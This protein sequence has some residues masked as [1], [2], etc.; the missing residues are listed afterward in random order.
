MTPER[1][2]AV[3]LLAK[4]RTLIARGVYTLGSRLD[5][6]VKTV[7][8]NVAEASVG[9]ILRA[10]E[11]YLLTND[12]E[13]LMETI[14]TTAQ[15]RHL[16]GYKM[17][18]LMAMSHCYLPVIR[19][20][21]QK[22]GDAELAAFDVVESVGLPFIIR[23]LDELYLTYADHGSDFDDDEITAKRNR[24]DP[25]EEPN[26]FTMVDVEEEITSEQ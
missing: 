5:P 22:N 14:R 15:L 19:K 13:P 4:H 21:F 23:M 25:T 12:P 17:Q 8:I 1:R 18:Q 11:S 20:V 24:A 9:N 10:L 16:T 6:V 26:P 3:E 2:R 7:P